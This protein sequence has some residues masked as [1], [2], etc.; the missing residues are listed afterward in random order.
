MIYRV[1]Q[2]SQVNKSDVQDYFQ[3][4]TWKP[5]LHRFFEAIDEEATFTVEFKNAWQTFMVESLFRMIEEIL[6]DKDII[7]I[8]DLDALTIEFD[9]YDSTGRLNVNNADFK[10]LCKKGLE[11]K[12]K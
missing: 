10:K 8:I 9:I 7:K 6:D 5:F 1:K 11:K 3:E 2:L 4:N 12:L